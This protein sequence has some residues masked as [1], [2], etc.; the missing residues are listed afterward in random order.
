MSPA[1]PCCVPTKLH[2]LCAVSF[3]VE[4]ANCINSINSEEMPRLSQ[5]PALTEVQPLVSEGEPELTAQVRDAT[6]AA[7]T[8]M[9]ALHAHVTCAWTCAC[10]D[11]CMDMCSDLQVDMCSDMFAIWIISNSDQ[12]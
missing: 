7:A 9:R 11:M 12:S 1:T 2:V 4:R 8:A 6:P 5:E 3:S 10:M